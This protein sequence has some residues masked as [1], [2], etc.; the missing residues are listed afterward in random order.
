MCLE[1]LGPTFIKLGQLLAS[2]PDVIPAPFVEELKKLQDRVP[3]LPFEQIQKTLEEQYGDAWQEIFKEIDEQPLGAASIAQVHRAV[4]QNGKEVVIKVQRPGI[5]KTIREDLQILSFIAEFFQSY[6]P[7]LRIFNPIGLVE[8][9][10]YSMQMETNFVVEGNNVRRFHENFLGHPTVKIPKPYLELS[11]PKVLVLEYLDGA[12]LTQLDSNVDREQLMKA[13]LEAYFAMVF[14]D[15][16]FHGDLH[17]GN[18]LVLPEGKLGFIDFG[19]VGRLS[20]RVQSSIANMFVALASEDYERLAY[21]YIE[22][23]SQSIDVDRNEFAR[24]LRLLLSPFFGLNLKSVN[25]GKILLDS[26]AIAFKHRVYLPSELLLFFKSIVTIEGLGRYIKDDFDLLP[27][28][29]DFSAEIVRLKYD[30]GLLVSDLSF[31]SREM[32]SLMKVVPG[33]IKNILRKVNQPDYAKRLEIVGTQEINNQI[34]NAS[35]LLFFAV[36]IASLVLAGALTASLENMTIYYGL[37]VISWVLFGLAINFG[38]LAFYHY[39]KK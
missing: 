32:T 23:S 20:K 19:M 31:F 15:G 39:I 2:R 34:A 18:I 16:L 30:P 12:I 6:V 13:G 3:A 14:R 7:E 1:E 29:Y 22:L 26:T 4:L 10:S 33:E 8:E 21:E 27:Y 11:G 9:F 35:Y 17:A 24:D 37:P 28:V 36:V 38:F 25:M 5:T